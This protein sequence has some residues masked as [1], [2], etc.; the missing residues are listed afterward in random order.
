MWGE[1][2]A[3]WECARDKTFAEADNICQ[4]AGARLCTTA[5]LLNRCAAGT[6]CEFDK[7]LVWAQHA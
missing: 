2:D 5:E 6:G 7:E 1:S 4:S 3:G